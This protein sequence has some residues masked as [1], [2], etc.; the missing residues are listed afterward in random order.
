ML[1][2]LKGETMKKIAIVV[3]LL[4]ASWG[5]SCFAA[6]S[7]ESLESLRVEQSQINETINQAREEDSKLSGGLIKALIEARLELLQINSA[8]IQ[9]RINALESGAKIKVKLYE[10]KPDLERARNLKSEMDSIKSEIKAKEEEI[11]KYRG[12]L[13]KVTLMSAVATMN[14]TLAM[15][16]TEYL[17]AKYGIYWMPDTNN[18]AKSTASSF[19][20]NKVATSTES[21]E[22]ILVPTITNK[23]YEKYKYDD[24][25]WFDITWN[26]DNLKKKTRAVKGVL[27]FADLFGEPKF[28]INKTINAPLSPHKPHTE[29]GIGFEYNQFKDSHKWMR[30][31]DLKDMTFRFEIKSIIYAD[32]TT[33]QF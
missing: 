29:D 27:I 28:M 4:L 24:N 22:V 32:G 2:E 17:K 18:K 9:Q 30:S 15:L 10:A 33:E 12:G 8:L 14:N 1:D 6:K 19:S 16:Q 23:R 13:I 3:A 21:D 31:S 20:V 25:I 5:T 11:A 26:T 7:E